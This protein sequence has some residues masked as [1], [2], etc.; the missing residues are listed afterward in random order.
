MNTSV[1]AA[2]LTKRDHRQVSLDKNMFSFSTQEVSDF[3]VA[4][5]AKIFAIVLVIFQRYHCFKVA[6]EIMDQTR[7]VIQVIPQF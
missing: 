5:N 3:A 2:V 7:V 6:L 1:L 4:F